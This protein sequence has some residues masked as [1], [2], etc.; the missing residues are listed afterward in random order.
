MATVTSKAIVDELIADDG[1]DSG[2]QLLAIYE[3]IRDTGQTLYS[4]CTSENDIHNLIHSPNVKEARL[5]WRREG[6]IVPT[7][8]TFVGNAFI[9]P[10]TSPGEKPLI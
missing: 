10:I 5:L 2:S 3:Y 9:V 6:A 4:I 1:W 8:K 7:G